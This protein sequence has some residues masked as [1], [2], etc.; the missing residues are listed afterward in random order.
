MKALLAP[1]CSSRILKN[2]GTDENIR[3]FPTPRMCL[4]LWCGPFLQPLFVPWSENRRGTEGGDL[5]TLIYP[6]SGRDFGLNLV[7]Y[8][9]DSSLAATSSAQQR[10]TFFAS[11]TMKP[12]QGVQNRGRSGRGS[13]MTQQRGRS[14]H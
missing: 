7:H 1:S 13:N 10:R 6:S 4:H 3:G 12:G 8:V 11:A 14:N 9:E 2:G 5:D